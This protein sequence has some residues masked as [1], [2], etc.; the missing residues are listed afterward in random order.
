MRQRR[1][2]FPF[3]NRRSPFEWARA[4]PLF[5]LA[6]VVF[7]AVAGILGWKLATDF[8]GPNKFVIVEYR[9]SD[10]Q[11]TTEGVTVSI[12]RLTFQPAFDVR[13]SKYLRT[14]GGPTLFIDG[15]IE[16]LSGQPLAAFVPADGQQS[17]A[18]LSRPGGQ[19]SGLQVRAV[20]TRRCATGAGTA[21]IIPPGNAMRFSIGVPME[22]GSVTRW[23][24]DSIE[25]GLFPQLSLGGFAFSECQ[26]DGSLGPVFS[27]WR[28]EFE[29]DTLKEPELRDYYPFGAPTGQ[30]IGLNG[31][32]Y[33]SDWVPRAN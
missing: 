16:N 6:G 21:S 20:G 28:V 27:Q 32:R 4:Y 33:W 29:A 18:L 15:R 1:E 14:Q 12:D 10:R 26:P 17:Q 7:L 24:K 13:I 8:I 11:V 25:S 31:R 3:R 2:D 30:T 23:V 22:K 5:A 9:E 19:V